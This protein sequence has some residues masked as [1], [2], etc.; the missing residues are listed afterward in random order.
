M[1]K[2]VKLH[3]EKGRTVQVDDNHWIKSTYRLEADVSDVP[4]PD[5]LE[6]LRLD[7]EFKID[8]WLRQT[9]YPSEAVG[10]LGVPKIDIAVLDACGWQTYKKEPAKVGQAAWIKNPVYFTQFEAP[11]A[12][13]E[14]VKALERTE[15]RKLVLG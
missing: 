5:E 2:I 3:V 10:A 11:P 9:G 14:L 12:L 15:D 8:D 4:S 7:L 13:L 6:K 1:P